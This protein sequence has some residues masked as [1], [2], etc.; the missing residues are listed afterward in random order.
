MCEF[1]LVA[2]AAF[3]VFAF[4]DPDDETVERASSAVCVAFF[5]LLVVVFL[6]FT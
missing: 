6:M 2:I 5:V 3:V 4:I 1:V